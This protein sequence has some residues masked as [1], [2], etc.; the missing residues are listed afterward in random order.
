MIWTAADAITI[1]RIQRNLATGG[2]DGKPE[3]ENRVRM[4]GI[5]ISA[6][7]IARFAVAGSPMALMAGG[8]SAPKAAST[9][10]EQTWY[11]ALPGKAQEVYRL[12]LHACDVLEKLGLPR[13]HV[14]RRQGNS[15]T[16]PDPR[17]NA[18]CT[19]PRDSCRREAP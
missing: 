8:Q 3:K 4:G 18:T 9:I 1:L 15:E 7:T 10:V 17:R 12:R 14:L 16:L 2:Q 5:W 19:N 13:G 6:A 11:V